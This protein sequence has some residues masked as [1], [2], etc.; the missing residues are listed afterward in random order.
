MLKSLPLSCHA[1]DMLDRTTVLYTQL[2]PL[3]PLHH[4]LVRG[5]HKAAPPMITCLVDNGS[6]CCR[7]Y[8]RTETSLAYTHGAKEPTSKPL[9]TKQKQG[10]SFNKEDCSLFKS[11]VGCKSI[12]WSEIVDLY[13]INFILMFFTCAGHVRDE[14]RELVG[15]TV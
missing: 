9:K 3:P 14:G 5:H 2:L 12:Y 11:H 7:D 4:P 10:L 6:V 13:N 8:A 15:C 1:H